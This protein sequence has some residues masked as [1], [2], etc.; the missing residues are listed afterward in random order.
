MVS[1]C[2]KVTYVL[3]S[4]AEVAINL[5][6]HRYLYK[7][8]PKDMRLKFQPT[9]ASATSIPE[10]IIIY[11]WISQILLNSK[12]PSSEMDFLKA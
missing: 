10:A 1:T 6:K 3:K 11:I 2:I 4:A 9:L 5:Q 8:A 7:N 12:E